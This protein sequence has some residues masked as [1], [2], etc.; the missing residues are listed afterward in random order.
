MK[1]SIVYAVIR[2]EI[3]E[4]LACGIIM[5]DGEKAEFRYSDKKLR[6]LKELYGE[7]EYGFFETI[8]ENMRSEAATLAP[9]SID[10][11]NRYSN[12]LMA[13][14]PLQNIDIPYNADSADWIFTQY[15]DRSKR[16][17]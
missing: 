1:Y 10:Y 4:K 17:A 6:A 5:M 13:V 11:L 7:K 12:N 16:T 3:K 15:I 2:P 9:Q 14:S 8:M